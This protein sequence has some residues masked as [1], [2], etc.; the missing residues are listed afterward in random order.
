MHMHRWF[1]FFPIPRGNGFASA[2]YLFHLFLK[3]R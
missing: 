3:A 2:K 1:F